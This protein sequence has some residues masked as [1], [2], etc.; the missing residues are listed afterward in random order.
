[1]FALAVIPQAAKA[2]AL[3]C[4]LVTKTPYSHSRTSEDAPGIFTG[5]IDVDGA[6][7][8]G[9]PQVT[10]RPKNGGARCSPVE[11]TD[12]SC[13]VAHPEIC[14]GSPGS[15]AC[16]RAILAQ[17]SGDQECTFLETKE[18]EV[19]CVVYDECTSI[20]KKLSNCG[21]LNLGSCEKAKGCFW[22]GSG[23]QN[24]YDR[25]V[26]S[27]LKSK[28]TCDGPDGSQTC[29]WNKDLKVCITKIEGVLSANRTNESD[30]LPDCAVNG[31]CRSLDD[32][33]QTAIKIARKLFGLF[34]SLAFVMFIYGGV[35]MIASF[36]NPEQF[37]KGKSILGAAIV[38][39]IIAFASFMLIG[40]VLQA[41]GVDGELRS[42]VSVT[43][44]STPKKPTP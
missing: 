10:C 2:V 19:S 40:Y 8:S 36:G 37:Q 24:K 13:S 1:M 15:D 39:I 42:G 9:D 4:C 21:N 30:I 43:E 18:L 26:C 14:I 6:P 35:R 11:R 29:L 28:K 34:G 41:L 3:D 20:L 5:N 22:D 32:L 12:S 17:S 27:K 44:P 7:K 16:D 23:C 25:S 33:V 38:G 31:T